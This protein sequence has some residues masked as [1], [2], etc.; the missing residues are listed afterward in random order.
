M[1]AVPP[2]L[3]AACRALL[4]RHAR[5]FRLASWFLPAATRDDAAIVYALCR[6]V[7]DLADE[8]GDRDALLAIRDELDGKTAPRPLVEAFRAVSPGGVPAA[9]DLVDGAIGDLDPVRVPDEAAL[10]RYGYRVA[11]TVGLMMASLLGADRPDARAHAIDLGIGMQLSNIARDVDEDARRG[12]VYLPADWLAAEGVSPDAI[13]AGRRDE[14]V[15]RVVARVVARAEDY[16]RSGESGLVYLP[17]RTRVAILVASRAYRAIGHG[18]V[19]RGEAAL[20]E[21]TVVSLL[22][23]V[24]AALSGV[25]R[26]FARTHGH[27]DRLHLPLIG[28]LS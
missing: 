9:L 24:I 5:T 28:V 2:E 16:Y 25:G 15:V 3:R 4:D 11:G 12:R 14:A 21:R 8:T 22:G 13:L 20:R 27:D 18:V 6:T 23:K 26:L 10:V 19:R 17:W 1:T 7:D